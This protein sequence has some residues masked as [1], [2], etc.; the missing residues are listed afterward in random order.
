[1]PNF[2]IEHSWERIMCIL[3]AYLV[4]HFAAFS[5]V[6][7]DNSAHLQ[8]VNRTSSFSWLGSPCAP[9]TH[10]SVRPSR[11]WGPLR[12]SSWSTAGYVKHTRTPERLL[13]DL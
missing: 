5:R 2:F 4:R 11:H 12:I 9:C 3:P 13:L 1:M 6:V 10:S 8:A 7:L